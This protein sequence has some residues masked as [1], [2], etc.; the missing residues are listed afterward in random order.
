MVISFTIIIALITFWDLMAHREMN[1][2][3]KDQS[4]E[5]KMRIALMDT[6]TEAFI[7]VHGMCVA[8]HHNKK[9]VD[10]IDICPSIFDDT[11]MEELIERVKK[12][13]DE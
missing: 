11:T 13:L 8:S 7:Y 6:E 12:Q 1:K 4:D 10:R 3:A 2:K 5:I 9:G